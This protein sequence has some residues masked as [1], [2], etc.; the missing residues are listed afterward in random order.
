MKSILLYFDGLPA[1]Q[2]AL[3]VTEALYKT[4]PGHLALLYVRSQHLLSAPPQPSHGAPTVGE[5]DRPI[6]SVSE[7]VREEEMRQSLDVMEKAREQLEALGIKAD[8]LIAEGDLLDEIIKEASKS[9]DLLMCP[10]AVRPE[11]ST[12][13]ASSL[14]KLASRLACSIYV[15]R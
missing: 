5:A 13:N 12:L 10:I 4:Y 7:H 8:Y 6:L 14:Q 11:E 15:V 1:S 2:R 3:E 9:Y